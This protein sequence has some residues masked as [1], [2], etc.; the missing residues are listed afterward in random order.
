M[1]INF[2][3]KNNFKNNLEYELDIAITKR[4]EHKLDYSTFGD[5]GKIIYSIWGV[6]QYKFNINLKSVNEVM[7]D[8]NRLRVSIAHCTPLAKKG[9]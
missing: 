5:L 9:N 6:F 2:D 3:V 1:R 7:I 4:S 8:L